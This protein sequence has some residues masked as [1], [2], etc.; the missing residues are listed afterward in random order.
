MRIRRHFPRLCL[1]MAALVV[2]AS[3]SAG[4]ASGQ[5]I[6]IPC[7]RK[8]REPRSASR[9]SGNGWTSRTIS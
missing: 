1:G 8:V 9:K 4:P 3:A 7:I 6:V 2:A 5:G